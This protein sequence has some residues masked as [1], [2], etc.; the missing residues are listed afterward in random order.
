VQF[1]FGQ[2]RLILGTTV[3]DSP[4]FLPISHKNL[5]IL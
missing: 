2:S 4:A 3:S 5:F 1:P